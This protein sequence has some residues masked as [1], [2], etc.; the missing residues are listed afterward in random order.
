M[1]AGLLL[2]CL[3]YLTEV[4]YYALASFYGGVDDNFDGRE[5]SCGEIFDKDAMT[6]AHR[7]LP[8]GT[9]GEFTVG[10]SRAVGICNDDGPYTDR[11][12]DLSERMFYTLT[13]DLDMGIT[14]VQFRILGY[15]PRSTMQWNRYGSG[16]FQHLF[17][18]EIE[19][20]ILL[21]RECEIHKRPKPTT[22]NSFRHHQRP[23]RFCWRHF[24]N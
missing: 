10:D 4:P 12:F 20:F 16:Q 5:T 21:G 8:P 11:E 23:I 1:C 17:R 7:E 9:I 18:D 14:M 22:T 15:K 2:T 6:F 19:D 24:C 13:G 3:F